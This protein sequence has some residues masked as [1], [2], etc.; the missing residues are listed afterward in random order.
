LLT[1]NLQENHTRGS[2]LQSASTPLSLGEEGK[3]TKHNTAQSRICHC[4]A[5]LLPGH[6]SLPVTLFTQQNYM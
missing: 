4:K 1:K 2:L 5:C 3:H 6:L